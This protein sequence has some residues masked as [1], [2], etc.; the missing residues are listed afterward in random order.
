MKHKRE[1]FSLIFWLLLCQLPAVLGARVVQ[2]QLAWYHTLQTPP[3]APP[4]GLFGVAWEI[5]YVLLGTAAWLVF[6]RGLHKPVRGALFLFI[7]QLALNAWWTP[8]FFGQQNLQ[9]AWWLLVVML[10]EGAWLWKAFWKRNRAAGGL[11]IPYGAWLVFA[12]YLNTGFWWL[13]T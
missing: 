3:F 13:N 10:L 9:A 11:L 8:L 6:H 2:E 1:L 4:D 7:V 5:L 12:L